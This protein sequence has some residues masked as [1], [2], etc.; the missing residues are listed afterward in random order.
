M[1]RPNQYGYE[2]IRIIAAIAVVLL[3][4]YFLYKITKLQEEEMNLRENVTIVTEP[5]GKK[6]V[7]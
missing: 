3:V 1:I 6:I 4:R 2:R 7:I 5:T